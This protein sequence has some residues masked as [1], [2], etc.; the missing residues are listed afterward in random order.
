MHI[1]FPKISM[2]KGHVEHICN[3]VD[4]SVYCHGKFRLMTSPKDDK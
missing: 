1:T 4:P 2:R 3:I